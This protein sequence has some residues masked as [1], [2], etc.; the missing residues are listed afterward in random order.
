MEFLKTTHKIFLSIVIF[1]FFHS[2]YAQIVTA[3]STQHLHK[4]INRT[5]HSAILFSAPDCPSCTRAAKLFN[6]AHTK[7]QSS[8]ITF[9]HANTH[10]LE[11]F[12]KSNKITDVPRVWLMK[13]GQLYK[14]L[15]GLKHI[16]KKLLPSLQE[17]TSDEPANTDYHTT[18]TDKSDS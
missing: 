1:I 4:L 16:R 17:L 13:N 15:D 5:K 8:S 10:D 9:V 3:T 11:Q 6:T 12:A 2:G 7:T 18:T 14:E